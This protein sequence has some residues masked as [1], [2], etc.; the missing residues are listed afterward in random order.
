MIID[1]VGDGVV[2]GHV[3]ILEVRFLSKIVFFFMKLDLLFHSELILH[4]S[5]DGD[6]GGMLFFAIFILLFEEGVRV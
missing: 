2:P 3:L 4:F 5:L 6:I 1:G